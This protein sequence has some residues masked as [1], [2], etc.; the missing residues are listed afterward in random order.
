MGLG[1]PSIN[2]FSI[3]KVRPMKIQG[4]IILPLMVSY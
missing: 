1:D 2:L 3:R 4:K